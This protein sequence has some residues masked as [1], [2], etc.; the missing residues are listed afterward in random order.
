MSIGLGLAALG[1]PGYMTLGHGEDIA[2]AASPRGLEQR[3]HEVL[4][5][6]Y[7]GG[8]RYFDCA[9]SYG[10]GERFLGA[11]LRNRAIEPG[12]V[13]IAS[14]WGYRYT[15]DWATEADVHEV[16]EH[17]L[18]NLLRQFPQSREHLWEYLDIYQI[19]SAEISSGVLENTEVL[20]HLGRL[21]DEHGIEVGLSVTGPRQAET[22]D[23]AIGI[24]VEGRPLFGTVQATFN[25]LERSVGPALARAKSAGL[26]VVVKEGMANGRLGPRG[27]GA[28]GPSPALRTALGRLEASTGL[29]IDA[30]ALGAIAAQPSVD[31]VLSGA[32]TVAQH[33]SNLRAAE[34]SSEEAAELWASTTP[35]P[36]P[37]Y[38][39][40]RK[41]LGWT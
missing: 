6:A 24:E 23:R 15:A 13:T 11:W 12:T 41:T 28:H 10:L 20:H 38:W 16:K 1:R 25:L 32:S 2:G 14:K 37:T 7:D 31:V 21:R 3:C 40:H 36:A 9:R 26:R 34:L 35:E 17:T 18:E 5:A 22:V 4:D 29:P 8:V 19:H 30:L 33:R 27:V 39:S